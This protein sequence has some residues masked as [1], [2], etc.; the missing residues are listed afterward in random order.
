MRSETDKS[1]PSVNNGQRK[2]FFYHRS[3]RLGLNDN[4]EEFRV[5]YLR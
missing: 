3:N 4:S 5:R 1:S 2:E